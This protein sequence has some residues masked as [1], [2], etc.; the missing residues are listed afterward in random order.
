MYK[1]AGV[2]ALGILDTVSLSPDIISTI[3]NHKQSPKL[4]IN[5]QKPQSIVVVKMGAVSMLLTMRFTILCALNLT[6]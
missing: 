6:L 5:Q 1:S 3:N 2:K 4:T